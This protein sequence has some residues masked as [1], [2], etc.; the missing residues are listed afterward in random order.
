[1]KTTTE[2]RFK[3]TEVG[4]IPENWEVDKLENHLI[5]KGRL[6]WKGL[7]VSEYTGHGPFIIG[8]LQIRE[9]GVA[10]DECAHVSEAR[11]EESPEIMV[12]ESDILMTKDGTIGKLAYIQSLPG[13]AT[14]ASHIHVIRKRTEKIAPHFL[15]Y[16]KSPIFQN[17]VQSKISGSVIPALTQKD[18][19]EIIFPIPPISEQVS[20]SRVLSSLDSKIELNHQMNRTLEAIAQAIFKHWFVDFEF[21]NEE[22]KPYRSSG[23]EM[24]YNEELGKEIP[25]EWRAD[26]LGN[27]SIIKGRIGW[28]GLQVSEYVDEGPYIVGGTQLVDNRV[29]W[30][31]CPRVP[32]RRYDESPEIMLKKGDVLM[33]KDGTIGKLA[34]IDELR[35]PASVASG[36]FV[37][38]SDSSIIN[39]MYLW[40][41]FRSGVFGALVESR[42]EGSV[43]PHLYQRDITE[44]PVVLPTPSIA[45]QF[46][47]VASAIQRIFDANSNSSRTLSKIRDSLLP[48]LMSGKIRV[49]V[50]AR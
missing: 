11:Y 1:M 25:K 29:N 3:Q 39:Q 43:V 5:I 8:G 26:K 6:G 35:E 30:E 17:L 13:K 15:F 37:I 19:N 46:E 16:F 9:E 41:H 34:Y 49:P 36:I 12:R 24:V 44:M 48:K 4:E 45:K 31:D 47:T 14:V 38:R 42:I 28:K 50:G 10:W 33:T 27:H 7:M 23:G 2:T 22:G 32:Q 20:I 21:P 18:I 40:N